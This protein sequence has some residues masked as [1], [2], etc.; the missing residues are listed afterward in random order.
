MNASE[1][2]KAARLQEAIDAQ[3]KEVKANAADHGKR[4]FLFEL[5]AYAGDLDRARRQIDVVNYGD[6]ELD[7]AVIGYRKLLDAEEARR[8]LFKDGLV[9]KFY[10]EQPEHIHLRL[11]AINR[12]RENNPKEAAE[13][14]AKAAE[15]SP[16]VAG[17][18]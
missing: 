3:L 5:L 8:H 13:Y 7:A 15:L 12:L 18:L 17:K 10:G 9:P 2:Y 16:P 14:L 4:L 1:H 11:E 6:M